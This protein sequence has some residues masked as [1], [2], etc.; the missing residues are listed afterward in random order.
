[1]K[2]RCYHWEVGERCSGGGYR[3]PEADGRG[4]DQ[5]ACIAGPEGARKEGAYQA[6]GL[7]GRGGVKGWAGTPV[8]DPLD[9]GGQDLS[10]AEW[11]WRSL[12]A[13]SGPHWP[14]H[15]NIR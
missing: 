4:A 13:E 1:M 8:G 7:A 11:E 5:A 10:L 6:T 3:P 2:S 15:H 14:L 12:C 9:V